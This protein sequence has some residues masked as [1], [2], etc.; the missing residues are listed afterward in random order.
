MLSRF[1]SN[2][3]HNQQHIAARAASLVGQG[4]D[5][6]CSRA[7][8]G[9]DTT[10]T[11]R[12][13]HDPPTPTPH[14]R[15]PVA[16]PLTARPRWGPPVPLFPAIWVPFWDRAWFRRF[17]E[18]LGKGWIAHGRDNREGA[19]DL[20]ADAVVRMAAWEKAR[21]EL[22]GRGRRTWVGE[23]TGLN[24]GVSL[25]EPGGDLGQGRGHDA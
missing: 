13:Q 9:D 10:S 14:P 22:R 23:T 8:T 17:A 1:I 20:G 11:T 24:T 6:L 16:N 19:P 2:A 12:A 15:H 18:L 21:G 5:A 3:K 7:A 4:N 25:G